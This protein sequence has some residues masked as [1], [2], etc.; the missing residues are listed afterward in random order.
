[1]DIMDDKFLYLVVNDVGYPMGFCVYL[2]YI[3]C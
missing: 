3:L 2:N 1:M